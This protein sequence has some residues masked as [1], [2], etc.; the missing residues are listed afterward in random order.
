[1]SCPI[2]LEFNSVRQSAV[3][4]ELPHRGLPSTGNLAQSKSIELEKVDTWLGQVAS[5]AGCRQMH[6]GRGIF[7]GGPGSYVVKG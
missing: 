7:V 5:T 2:V 3:D 6:L 4:P 1:M